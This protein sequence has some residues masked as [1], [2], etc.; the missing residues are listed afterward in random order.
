MIPRF[1]ISENFDNDHMINLSNLNVIH[2]ITKVFRLGVKDKLILLMNDN[3]EHLVEIINVEK[4]YIEA[5]LIK[6]FENQKE[7]NI[8]INLFVSLPKSKEVYERILRQS[9]ELGITKIQPLKTQRSYAKYD[10]NKERHLLILKEAAEQSERGIIPKLDKLIS[11]DALELTEGLSI[12][13]DSYDPDATLINIYR[14]KAQ[15][16]NLLIGP[17][18]GFCSREIEMLKMKGYQTASLG[19]SILKVDTACITAISLIR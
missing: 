1:F 11:L 5:S 16:F 15:S 2:Q 3:K 13:A 17:E 19:K 10:P 18:G 6:S 7:L 14:N 9:C 12:V 4:K 8:K